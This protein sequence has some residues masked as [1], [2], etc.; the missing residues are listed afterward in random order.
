MHL[1]T[2]QDAKDGDILATCD[3][4]PFVFKG[5]LDKED[6]NRPFAYCG[7]ATDKQFW[8]STGDYCW[9]DEEVKPATKEQCDLLFQK[10]E[11][12][13]LSVMLLNMKK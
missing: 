4:R 11:E 1:W 6:P 9:T 2:I 5:C 12:H 13:K 10:M 7:I 8:C 3:G